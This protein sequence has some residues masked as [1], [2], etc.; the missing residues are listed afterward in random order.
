MTMTPNDVREAF[1][2]AM[3]SRGIIPPGDL[4]ADGRLHRCDTEGR[5]GRGDGAYLLYLDGRP[6]GGFQNFRDGIGWECWKGGAGRGL[7]PKERRRL[8]V[9]I[10][11]N[12][13]QRSADE[14]KRQ[15]EARAKAE[16]LWGFAEPCETH[17]YLLRKGVKAHGVRLH[18]GRLVV[19]LC[20]AG[21]RLHSLQFIGGDGSKRF[22]TG[23]RVQGCFHLIGEAGGVIGVS[24]GY[25]TAATIHE[26]TGLPVF[27]AF[28]C[29][30]LE[31]VALA[32]RAKY[33]AAEITIYAD[34]D[35]KTP[36]NPGLTKAI[37]AARAVG[38]E[39]RKPD[40]GENRPEGATDFNDLMQLRKGVTQ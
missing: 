30:N 1:R 13:K 16:A 23:G 31:A 18:R 34:D 3:R 26:E 40:F 24:E 35:W 19:P 14:A 10:E 8:K 22:L 39:V 33:P 29:D 32:V 4:L 2:D 36:G 15:G 28:N 17:P 6:A 27:V 12:Q 9:R 25:A 11:A 20:D 7:T 21:G 38:G 5:G 37:E